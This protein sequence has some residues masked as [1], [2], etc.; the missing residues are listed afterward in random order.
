[1]R[2]GTPGVVDRLRDRGGTP[3]LGLP[4]A[5]VTKPLNREID[6]VKVTDFTGKVKP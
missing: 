2:T 1:M 5:R 4:L 3:A 6:A